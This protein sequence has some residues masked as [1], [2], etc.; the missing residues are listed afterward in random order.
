MA[1]F[2]QQRWYKQFR[3]PVEDEDVLDWEFSVD[4]MV[5]KP[6]TMTLRQ[7]IERFEQRTYPITLVCAGNRLVSRYYY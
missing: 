2:E 3:F 7:L 4:G 5:E 6:F 1:A